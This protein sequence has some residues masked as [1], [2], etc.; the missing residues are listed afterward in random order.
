[1]IRVEPIVY[2]SFEFGWAVEPWA[3]AN[4]DARVKPLRTVVTGRS[5]RIRSD[6]IVSI[7][8]FG[9]YSD[10]DVDLSFCFGSRRRQSDSGNGS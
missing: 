1:M 9:R 10:V 2:V 7:R 3:G 5:A 6:V 4:E 8:T